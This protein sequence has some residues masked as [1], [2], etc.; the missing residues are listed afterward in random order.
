MKIKFN[1]YFVLAFFFLLSC[2]NE[3][4]TIS[5]ENI[6]VQFESDASF[7]VVDGESTA[8]FKIINQDEKQFPVSLFIDRVL[9]KHNGQIVSQGSTTYNFTPEEPGGHIFLLEF[10]GVV[11]SR[12]IIYAVEGKRK[13]E[14]P[15]IFHV[16]ES[17]PSDISEIITSVIESINEKFNKS[18]AHQEVQNNTVTQITFKLATHNPDGIQ[19]T[20]P[21]INRYPTAHEEFIYNS[22]YTWQRNYYWN[23]DSFINV[24][25]GKRIHGPLFWFTRL[26]GSF[27]HTLPQREILPKPDYGYARRIDHGDEPPTHSPEGI[28]FSYLDE[29]GDI[30]QEHQL[31]GLVNLFGKHLGL[32]PVEVSRNFMNFSDIGANDHFTYAQK[33][34]MWFTIDYAR[35]RAREGLVFSTSD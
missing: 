35:W 23:P 21:G 4:D 6:K 22:D 17:E 34:T 13:V 15:V 14:V 3:E 9:I 11:L 26:P 31:D 25:I 24:W 33:G 20:E 19:L 28:T 12:H 10:D 16:S 7:L 30:L 18:D 29:P 32:L 2:T 8:H 1:V 5:I 27:H